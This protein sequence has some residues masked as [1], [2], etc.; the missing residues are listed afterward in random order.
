[1]SLNQRMD[2]LKRYIHTREYYLAVKNN[3]IIKFAGKR[4]ELE[5]IILSVITQTQKDS[6]V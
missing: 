6:I 5:K 3:D 2:F 4:M 1:M